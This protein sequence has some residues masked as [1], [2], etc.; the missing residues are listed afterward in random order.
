VYSYRNDPGADG[1]GIAFFDAVA[2]DGGRL[3]LGT[4]SSA[5]RRAEDWDLVESD[6]GVRIAAVRQV[7]GE[8]VLVVDEATDRPTLAW[9]PADALA[10]TSAGVALAVRA[11][12][13]LPVLLADPDAGVVGAA[14]AGRVG[15]AAGVLA[16]LVETLR[17]L[18]A[19]RLRAWIG[20]HICGACY[21]VPEELQ[22]EFVAV[23]PEALTRTSWGT[24]SLDLG[25]AAQA[26]LAALGCVVHR[27]D[28]CTFTTPTLHS[29]RRD[30]AAAGRQ[31]G[32]VWLP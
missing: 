15:L 3:D 10:T 31:A 8:R 26:Q 1:V 32:L 24:P 12:D 18:G 28:P 25:A 16:N 6:L 9:T 11:A 5:R 29:Y 30:G 4:T 23:H 21:E 7:H 13:C 19:G 17:G 27:V 2:P 20:P 14:H 22:S